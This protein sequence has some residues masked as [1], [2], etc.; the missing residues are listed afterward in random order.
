MADHFFILLRPRTPIGPAA[1]AS[2]RFIS[3]WIRRKQ[4]AYDGLSCDGWPTLYGHWPF[5][6][7]YETHERS[8]G[9][10]HV[11]E[12]YVSLLKRILRYRN[13]DQGTRTKIPVTIERD[14]KIRKKTAPR[15]LEIQ[16]NGEICT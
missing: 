15:Q 7:V 6:C 16:K 8:C 14:G 9:G 13:S 10:E 1:L 12:M 3:I 11:A 2:K 5:A 4:S